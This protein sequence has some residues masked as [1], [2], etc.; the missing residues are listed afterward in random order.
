MCYATYLKFLKYHSNSTTEMKKERNR[1]NIFSTCLFHYRLDILIR[2]VMELPRT[3][4]LDHFQ[5]FA[6]GILF[7]SVGD[8]FL[9]LHNIVILLV[10]FLFFFISYFP[11]NDYIYLRLNRRN[12]SHMQQRY[13]FILWFFFFLNYLFQEK[14]NRMYE[15]LAFISYS[16]AYDIFY[17]ASPVSPIL[18]AI[19]VLETFILRTLLQHFSR[20]KISNINTQLVY[21]S[22]CS[23]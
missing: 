19:F 20:V 18:A 17:K 4:S 8:T 9:L 21:Y 3:P 22:F 7:R 13:H 1:A 2:E 6:K 16:I 11:L 23:S 15:E 12:R 14:G 10:L 5:S